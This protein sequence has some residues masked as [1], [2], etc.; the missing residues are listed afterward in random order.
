MLRARLAD[1]KFFFDDDLK[2]PL[3]KMAEGLGGLTFQE[4]LGSY[5]E[6]VLRM[7]ALA[8]SL[9]AELKAGNEGDIDNAARLAK[10][11]LKSK[12]VYEFPELQGLMGRSYAKK[13]GGSLGGAADAIAEHYQPRFAGDAIPASEAGA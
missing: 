4:K 13:A 2:V 11:D 7:R 5:A 8:K 3:E 6:K 1:A 10:A 9:R 12:M